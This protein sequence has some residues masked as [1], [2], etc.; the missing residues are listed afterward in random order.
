MVNP[1]TLPGRDLG[2]KANAAFA[3]MPAAGGTVRIPAGTFEYGTP[4]R[5]TRPGEHLRCDAGTVLHYL[6]GSDAIILD[7]AAA[8]NASLTIDGEGGCRLTGNTAAANGIHLLPGNSYVVRGMRIDGFANGIEL[9]GANSVQILMNS[10]FGNRHGIDMVTL[11]HY[12]PNAVH[13]FGNEIASN[14]WAV[15]SRNGHVPASRALGNVYRDNVFEGNRDGDLFLGWDA[16]TIVEGNY[17]ESSGVAVSAGLGGENVYDIHVIRNYFTVNGAEGYRSEVEL[18]YGWGFTIE[19][20]YEEGPSAG[21]SSGC[22]INAIAGPHGGLI[23]VVVKNA[24]LRESEAHTTTHELC[25]Q[26]S[27]KVPPAILGAL[28]V[29][30]DVDAEGDIRARSAALREGLQVGHAALTSADRAPRAGD[31]CTSEGTLLIAT[32]SGQPASL[33]FCSGSHWQSAIVPHS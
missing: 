24:F 21:A 7:P 8:G 12:A 30:G 11:P 14:D 32:P 16:H 23:D 19:G 33:W 22:A 13:V 6:G 2:E 15:Y 1:L 3:A 20:N 31:S 29:G 27:P 9:S 25:Y 17:F 5:M 26:G 4:I 18:G 28:R 10:L